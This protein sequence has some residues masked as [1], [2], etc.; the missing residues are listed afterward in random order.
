MTKFSTKAVRRIVQDQ[1][2]L[3][4]KGKKTKEYYFDLSRKP[5]DDLDMVHELM[6]MDPET[7]CY[8]TVASTG[9]DQ[10]YIPT[11]V[12]KEFIRQTA[13]VQIGNSGDVAWLPHAVV[14]ILPDKTG[15]VLIEGTYFHLYSL[16]HPNNLPF[17]QG[18]MMEEMDAVK[19]DYYKVSEIPLY[20]HDWERKFAA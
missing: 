17:R 11:S 1:K 8:T 16:N 18:G 4:F 10:G 12:R 5:M 14:T 19:R 2:A 6:V 3:V 20:N 13:V 15:L 9:T 7:M